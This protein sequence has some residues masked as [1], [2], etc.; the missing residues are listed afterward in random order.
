MMAVA[1]FL[2]VCVTLKKKAQVVNRRTEMSYDSKLSHFKSKRWRN[3]N[4]FDTRLSK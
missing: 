2:K 3:V 1:D 4:I